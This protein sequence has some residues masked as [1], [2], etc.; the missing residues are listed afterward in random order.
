MVTFLVSS[1]ICFPLVLLLNVVTW[2]LLCLMEQFSQHKKGLCTVRVENKDSWDPA[3]RVRECL[4]PVS[5][6]EKKTFLQSAAITMTVLLTRYQHVYSVAHSLFHPK[7][8]AKP[9]CECQEN[10]VQLYK[11]Y[12]IESREQKIVSNL[13][14]YGVQYLYKHLI[15]SALLQ[16]RSQLETSRWHVPCWPSNWTTSWVVN[17][18]STDTFRDTKPQSSWPSFPEGSATR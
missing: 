1:I 4:C 12:N 14:S 8:S 2:V 15:S 18:S 6:T 5:E 13:I 9:R 10:T 7:F 17:P 16:A 11:V 3:S